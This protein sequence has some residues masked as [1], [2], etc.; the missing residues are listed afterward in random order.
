MLEGN[1]RASTD[2]TS[3]RPWRTIGRGLGVSRGCRRAGAWGSG[4][5]R[6]HFESVRREEPEHERTSVGRR[7]GEF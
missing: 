1:K 4:N 3:Q 7:R 2:L 6:I 5:D